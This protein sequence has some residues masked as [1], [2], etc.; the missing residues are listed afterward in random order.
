VDGKVTPVI[1]NPVPASVPAL[2]VR[3]V[4]PDELS[5]TVCV[6]GV[7]RST[8]PKDTVVEVSVSPGAPP[9]NCRLK[10]FATPLAVAESVAVCVEVTAATVAVNAPVVVPAGTVT[11]ASTVT[12]VLLLARVTAIPPVGAA[13]LSVTVQASVP[14]A[15]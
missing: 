8:L 6:D 3:A 1:V 2:S 11:D 14:A 10:V 4:P 13:A 15:V 5:V 7:F 9:V 12:E